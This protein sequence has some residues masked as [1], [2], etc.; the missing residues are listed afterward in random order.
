MSDMKHNIAA[1]STVPGYVVVTFAGV[2]VTAFW[3]WHLKVCYRPENE[4][5]AR[6]VFKDS[7]H[8]TTSANPGEVMSAVA[9]AMAAWNAI[10]SQ[11]AS[12][13]SRDM[14]DSLSR[15]ST[16]ESSFGA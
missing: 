5:G 2:V 11:V 15:S 10:A 7:W 14:H 16:S 3:S 9:A 1:S 12:D 13:R 4:S 8:L 6:L